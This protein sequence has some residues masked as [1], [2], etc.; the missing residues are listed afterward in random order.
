M[1]HT[2]K[3]R[4]GATIGGG[5][6]S[7]SVEEQASFAALPIPVQDALTGIEQRFAAQLAEIKDLLTTPPPAALREEQ[8]VCAIGTLL[9]D[10]CNSPEDTKYGPALVRAELQDRGDF[11]SSAQLRGRTETARKVEIEVST[12]IIERTIE[13]RIKS[14]SA[15]GNLDKDDKTRDRAAARKAAD[16][17]KRK[18]TDAASEKRKATAAAKAAKDGQLDAP[19]PRPRAQSQGRGH[20]DGK[21]DTGAA[22]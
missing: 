21:D 14:L 1:V 18:S 7:G 12:K 22:K 4:T 20:G 9:Y 17:A 11:L 3:V 6:D 2:P 8:H 13:Q 16:A 10:V 15:G 19:H 5:Q